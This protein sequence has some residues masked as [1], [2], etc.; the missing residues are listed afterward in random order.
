VSIE[1]LQQA[2]A[3]TRGVLTKVT[4]DQLSAP[5]PC[6][7]W[8][9]AALINHIVGAQRFFAAGVDG[10]EPDRDADVA[11]GDYVQA[12]D[13]GAAALMV[14]FGA[15][16]VMERMLTLP[17]GEM[18]GAAFAGLATT[19]TFQHG[20]DLAK[21]TGQSTDL[22]PEL[23]E[24]LLAQSKAAIQ[25]AFRGPEGAPFGPEKTVVDDA[26]AADRLAAFLG[27][28]V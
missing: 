10:T 14:A 18:P 21:A 4:P 25:D 24:A 9:V 3:V 7:S 12:F 23:A 17:F 16:G 5:T 6:A 13:D 22:A 26:P 20:W 19:D 15:D 2:I 8:D 11:A 1:P 27:R 28:T